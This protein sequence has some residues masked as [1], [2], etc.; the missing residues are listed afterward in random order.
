MF[1]LAKFKISRDPNQAM[2]CCPFHD[3]TNP[4]LSID[5]VDGRVNCFACGESAKDIIDFCQKRYGLGFIPA[6][7]KIASEH[8]PHISDQENNQQDNIE[9]IYPYND[10]T[11]KLLFEAVRLYPKGFFQR[12]PDGTPGIKGIRRVPYRVNEWHKKYENICIVEGEKDANALW[13][14]GLPATTNAGGHQP[15]N[16]Q[17]I[18]RSLANHLQPGSA[19]HR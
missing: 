2:A 3:D 7:N 13:K 19:V 8:A 16:Q 9:A 5:L 12:K 15:V 6:C 1:E 14:L 4:S 11:G 17:K 10:E 18:G